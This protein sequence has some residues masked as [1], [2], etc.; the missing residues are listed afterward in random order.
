MYYFY[1]R[2]CSLVVVNLHLTSGVDVWV[3][4]LLVISG[5]ILVCLTLNNR[6]VLLLY[7]VWL[8][9]LR[10]ILCHHRSLVSTSIANRGHVIPTMCHHWSLVSTSIAKR[11]HVIT[12]LCYHR[13]LVSTSIAN[14]GHAIPTMCHYWSLV[15]TSIA[16][17]GHVIPTM[18]HRW[19]LVSTSIANRGH[20]I[21]TMCHHWS[22]VSTSIANRGH[23]I[24]TMCH[25]WSLVS[26][27][28]AKRAGIRILQ[29]TMPVS[30]ALELQ[31]EGSVACLHRISSAEHALSFDPWCT[32]HVAT[33]FPLHAQHYRFSWAR[34]EKMFRRHI[35]SLKPTAY[36]FCRKGF[37]GPFSW[38]SVYLSFCL[39]YCSIAALT[40]W[41]R[42]VGGDRKRKWSFLN[43]W[44]STRKE[45]KTKQKPLIR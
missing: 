39:A 6:A 40:G 30:L 9:E 25:E 33:S 22:L 1:S 38:V 31:T 42:G 17:R 10:V 13:S 4:Q 2:V 28:I 19:S 3:G 29:C 5:M 16:N 32:W 36:Y 11:G 37:P 24:P 7:W 14:R 34:Q 44:N 27:S 21:P 26:T 23:V 45:K 43:D 41:G 15:G 12:T 35:H 8:C 20:V 18:C